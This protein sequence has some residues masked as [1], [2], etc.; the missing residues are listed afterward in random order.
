MKAAVE[1][2]LRFTRLMGGSFVMT[3]QLIE[4][5]STF[6]FRGQ[7]DRR[8]KKRFTH[9]GFDLTFDLYLRELACQTC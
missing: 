2:E 8:E 5:F 6:A 7:K 3:L 1:A 9:R 4:T